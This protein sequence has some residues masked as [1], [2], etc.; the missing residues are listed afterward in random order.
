MVTRE[1]KT[2]FLPLSCFRVATEL[3]NETHLWIPWTR[4]VKRN[5]DRLE[6]CV[7]TMFP[8]A[9]G[10][11]SQDFLQAGHFPYNVRL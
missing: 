2:R 8:A 3:E 11:G 7:I 5:G 10:F 4:Y 6:M 1:G 9:T